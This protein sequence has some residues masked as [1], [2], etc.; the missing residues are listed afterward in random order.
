MEK[1]IR[2]L[3]LVG[4]GASLGSTFLVSSAVAQGQGTTT[5]PERGTG[6]GTG[7]G[8]QGEPGM[9]TRGQTGTGSQ[10]QT[11]T[12]TGSQG[13]PG[14]GQGQTGTGTQ[15]Q[16]GTGTGSQ[17]QPGMEQGQTGSGM[18]SQGE[19]AQQRSG[20]TGA[21]KPMGRE[22]SEVVT[23]AATVQEVDKKN[24]RVT[25]TD[26]QGERFE[27]QV[28]ADMA[29]FDRLKKGDKVNITYHEAM[30]AALLP[31]GTAP[32]T[33]TM[34]ERTVVG[35][36]PLG[37]GAMAREFSVTLPVVSVDTKESAITV[38]TPEGRNEKVKV[39][40]PSI[41]RRLNEVKPGDVVQLTYVEAVA[42]AIEPR[43]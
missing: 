4:L 42:T 12:G 40:D 1:L 5:E 21:R 20:S 43:K 14:M 27:V 39:A 16:T 35:Q 3:C 30:A 9:G 13:Q 26:E 41:K 10:G 8:S 15:G 7:T 18:E 24:R 33:P 29:G 23:V 37:G 36:R 38:K 32:A 34:E 25:L 17:G 6:T 19:G 28:P 22:V 2:T 11:G 31:A